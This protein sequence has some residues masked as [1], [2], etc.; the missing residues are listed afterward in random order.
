VEGHDQNK[1]GTPHFRSE[2]VPAPSPY[3]QIRSGATALTAMG[4]RALPVLNTL[5]LY[6]TVGFYYDHIV[7]VVIIVAAGRGG[8]HGVDWG[9]HLQPTVS[10]RCCCDWYK[11]GWVFTWV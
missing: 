8:R 6:A 2:P 3:F 5:L 9:R 1:I 10:R 11:S 4:A 7:T